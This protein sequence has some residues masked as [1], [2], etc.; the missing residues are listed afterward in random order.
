MERASSLR[1]EHSDRCGRVLHE[2]WPQDIMRR[3]IAASQ[4]R[5]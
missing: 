1:E 2:A 3:K 5:T 4:T